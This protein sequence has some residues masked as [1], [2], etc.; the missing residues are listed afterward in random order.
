[1]GIYPSR[2]RWGENTLR[3]FVKTHIRPI[4][5]TGTQIKV[6]LYVK[7]MSKYD[8]LSLSKPGAGI[9]SKLFYLTQGKQEHDYEKCWKN[10]LQQAESLKF[11]YLEDTSNSAIIC[12]IL[13]PFVWHH[14]YLFKLKSLAQSHQKRYLMP[15]TLPPIIMEV[16]NGCISNSSYLSNTAIFHFQDYGRK[17]TCNF[18]SRTEAFGPKELVHV[19]GHNK[20]LPTLGWGMIHI[21]Q[22]HGALFLTDGAT[23]D[24]A[25]I[26]RKM[27]KWWC[28]FGT[29][30]S[31]I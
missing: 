5:P 16:R 28:K 3:N 27:K 8:M 12:S 9:W 10:D 30:Y 22:D 25:G 29:M 1:M 2:L 17:G 4:Q 11:T 24:V 13:N 21:L 6:F 23:A 19:Q 18:T 14:V 20:L 15:T 7:L 31:I 26:L